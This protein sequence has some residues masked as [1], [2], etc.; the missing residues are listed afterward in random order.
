LRGLDCSAVT[1]GRF[2]LDDIDLR[3]ARLAKADLRRMRANYAKLIAADLRRANLDGADLSR[4]DLSRV[5]G[6]AVRLVQSNLT[7]AIAKGAKLQ[8]ANL[9]HSTL[10]GLQ[11]QGADL[12]GAKVAG[13]SAWN[14]A[15]DGSTRQEHLVLEDVGDVLEELSSDDRG[16]KLA[17]VA[18]VNNLKTAYLLYL[19]TDKTKLKA[20]IDALTDNLVLLLGNFRSRRGSVLHAIEAKLKRMGYAPVIFD[21][22]AP[23]DRDLIETVALLAGLSCFVIADLTLPRSTPLESMLVVPQ[24]AVPF[25]SI[26]KTGEEPFAMFESLQ[27]KYRWALPTVFYRDRAHLVRILESRIVKPC[28]AMRGRLRTWR[29]TAERVRKSRRAASRVRS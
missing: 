21:F 1:L 14:V 13:I 7:L 25:A 12:T 23:D 9:S 29:R 17:V 22:D 6:Q 2:V 26:V 19:V 24:L 11:L 28:K 18:N 27:V 15:T 20:V 16:R 8:E 10:N 5:R 4:A 3:R